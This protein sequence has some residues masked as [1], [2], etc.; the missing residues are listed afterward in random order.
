MF[1]GN[2]FF[3]KLEIYIYIIKSQYYTVCDTHT[4]CA[5]KCR[6]K[7]LKINKFPKP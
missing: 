6:E 7:V 1:T 5:V 2:R 4:V 3:S